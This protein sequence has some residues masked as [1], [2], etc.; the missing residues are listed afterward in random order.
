MDSV[1]DESTIIKETNELLGIMGTSESL[2]SVPTQEQPLMSAPAMTSGTHLQPDSQLQPITGQ[3]QQV[4]PDLHP[5]KEGTTTVSIRY[6]DGILLAADS[7]GQRRGVTVTNRLEKIHE[8]EPM[9]M[10]ATVSGS[11]ERC[12]IWIDKLKELWDSRDGEIH[13]SPDEAT[14]W[15]AYRMR[16]VGLPSEGRLAGR[17]ARLIVCGYEEPGDNIDVPPV[18][19]MCWVDHNG[20]MG[21]AD[22][23]LTSGSG[24]DHASRVL[25]REWREGMT[26]EEVARLASKSICFASN[27]N[28]HTGGSVHYRTFTTE[29]FRVEGDGVEH[30][31]V[32]REFAPRNIRSMLENEYRDIL[33]EYP[34]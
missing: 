7:R 21:T 26:R 18:F 13:I 10:Y 31:E 12:M 8:I 6:R 33:L 28:N 9:R 20:E 14:I 11:V 16:Q 17:I 30:E 19:S 3:E 23:F 5:E 4:T 34:I 29:Y 2:G 1:P 27:V 25:T 32:R 15:L 24:K 22:D